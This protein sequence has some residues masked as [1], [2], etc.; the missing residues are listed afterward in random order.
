MGLW[1]AIRKG[2]LD[3]LF[4]DADAEETSKEVAAAQQALIAERVAQGRMDPAKAAELTQ[5][6]REST[7]D[8][9]LQDPTN[10]PAKTFTSSVAANFDRGLTLVRNGIS[11]TVQFI[12]GSVFKV[13]PWWIWLAGI[14][15]VAVF[16]WPQLLTGFRLFK[17]LF[18]GK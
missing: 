2:S 1:D 7:I 18:R 8:A 3:S 6:S 12:G 15:A 11:E 14:A 17:G 13:L 16:F 5:R 9:L 4:F 10:S